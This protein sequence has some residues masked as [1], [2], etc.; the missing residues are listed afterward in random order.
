M[1]G[2]SLADVMM[3]KDYTSLGV[4]FTGIVLIRYRCNIN[5]ISIKYSVNIHIWSFFSCFYF[6][7]AFNLLGLIP[8]YYGFASYFCILL[9][10]TALVSTAACVIVIHTVI[11]IIK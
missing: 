4:V 2:W 9:M 11:R 1:L 6:N 3:N 7:D 8:A 5:E 10:S